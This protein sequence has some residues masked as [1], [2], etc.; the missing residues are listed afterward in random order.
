MARTISPAAA[1]NAEPVRPALPFRTGR[2]SP[3]SPP[4]CQIPADRATRHAMVG[5]YRA[6]VT[7]R[8]GSG[9]RGSRQVEAE[10]GARLAPAIGSL[11]GRLGV[12]PAVAGKL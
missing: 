1:T 10:P 4:V 8:R 9:Q 6:A 7:C 2:G 5:V 11:A 3:L 12:E